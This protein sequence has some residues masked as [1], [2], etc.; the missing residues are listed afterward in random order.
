MIVIEIEVHHTFIEIL[1]SRCV[2]LHYLIDGWLV[3]WF[4]GEV[5]RCMVNIF[6]R[7]SSGC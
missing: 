5:R 1:L 3:G 6:N 7:L 4:G 2:S